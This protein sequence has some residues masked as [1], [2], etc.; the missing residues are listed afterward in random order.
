MPDGTVKVSIAGPVATVTLAR[1]ARRNALDL[2]MLDALFHAC[3]E[4]D[5]APHVRA[6]ILTGEGDAFC[7]GG[8]IHA[9]GGMGPGDFGH[10]W[11]RHG[12]RVFDRLATLRMPLIAAINGHALGGGLEIAATADIRIAET[13]VRVG[14][15]E[16]SL[17]MVPGWSGTQ[18]LVRR[19]GAQVV[20]RMALG[21]EVLTAGEAR[22]LGIFD[23]VVATGTALPAAQQAADRIVGRAPGATEAIKLMISI[24]EG[25][26][27]GAAVD[28]LAA[29]AVSGRPDMTE[30]VTAFREK[31]APRFRGGW[32]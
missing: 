2:G 3:D 21:G 13:H 16:A 32:S 26:D 31:R 27:R 6:A 18:R 30:G 14:L 29:I 19:L 10:N 20:R 12:H 15:P 11:V 25:E 9:W 4:V 28:A 8:D 24:A 1:P 23:S 17:G 5:G 22:D 7:A